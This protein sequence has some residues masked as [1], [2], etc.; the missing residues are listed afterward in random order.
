MT[1]LVPE[2][3]C[4][5]FAAS[6][7]LYTE[8][9][10]FTQRYGR[11]GFAYLEREGA[12]LMLEQLGE[13]SWLTQGEG[14]GRGVNFQIEVDEL[15][16]LITRAKAAQVQVFRPAETVTYR[17]GD[18]AVTQ[19]QIVFQDPDGYLLRFCEPVTTGTADRVV[20]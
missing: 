11:E 16:S 15:A 6:L 9:F 2:L 17:T 3:Y 4:R 19:R 18:T 13:A 10:G 12:E 1:R 5:D 8:V 7:K 14:L 20:A